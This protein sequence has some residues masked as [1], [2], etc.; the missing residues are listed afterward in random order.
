MFQSFL[1]DGDLRMKGLS[2]DAFSFKDCKFEA[3]IS[4]KLS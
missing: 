3:Q 2:D 1:V 4:C